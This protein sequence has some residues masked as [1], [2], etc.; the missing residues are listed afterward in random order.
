MAAAGGSGVGRP[1]WRRRR[2][3]R[4]EREEGSEIQASYLHIVG[5]GNWG[6]AWVSI[7][8]GLVSFWGVGASSSEADVEQE[9]EESK[10]S[11]ESWKRE[12]SWWS[13]STA[14]VMAC[15]AFPF[16]SANPKGKW[17]GSWNGSNAGERVR[18]ESDP[19]N[20]T[21]R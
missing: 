11:L 19:M 18:C 10:R 13:S 9:H 3:R 21:V 5:K 8:V 12:G 15:G 16:G 2:E 7:L 14:G 6:R 17:V 4:S 1:N 20:G